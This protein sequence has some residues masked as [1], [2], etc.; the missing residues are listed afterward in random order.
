MS[1]VMA[2]MKAATAGLHAE[3]EGL[4]PLARRPLTRSDYVEHL[5]RLAGFH[6]P[7]EAALLDG[8]DWAGL[9]LIDVD[10]RRRSGALLAD[11][12]ALGVSPDAPPRCPPAAPGD[13]GRALGALYVLEGSTL[14][15]LVIAR[16][17]SGRFDPP[18]PLGYLSADGPHVGARWKAFGAFAEGLAGERSIAD[19]A[20]AGAV[21]TFARLAAWLAR[22]S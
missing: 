8:F 5:V 13:L 7:L 21:D 16:E 12:A 6:L 3:V 18:V 10:R 1:G 11:L 19:G 2:A 4:V 17:L 9:G 15:G 22:P 14:G 20:V